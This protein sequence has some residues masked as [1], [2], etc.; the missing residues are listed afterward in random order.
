MKTSNWFFALTALVLSACNP[1]LNVPPTDINNQKLNSLLTLELGE[2]TVYTQDFIADVAMIDSVTVVGEGIEVMLYDSRRLIRVD[3]TEDAGELFD[4]QLWI[5]GNAYS[6][7]CR[8]SD[9]VKYNFVYDPQGATFERVQLAGQMNDWTPS[10][11]PDLVLNEQGKYETE[12]YL[13]PGTYLYQMSIDGEQNHDAGNP[14][15]VDNGYGKFNSILQVPGNHDRL[16]VLITRKAEHRKIYLSYQQEIQEL[17]VYWQNHRLPDH[18]VRFGKGEIAFDMPIEASKVERSYIRIWASNKF[19]VGREVLI[20]LH[21][22][23]PVNDAT[24]LTRKDPHTQIMYFM[25]VDRFKNGSVSND[26]PMNRPDVHPKVDYYGGDLAGLQQ[27]IDSGYFERLGVNTLWISPLS[28][29]P[30]E[31]YGYYAPKNTKFSGYHGYWPVSSSKV[32]DRF[33]SNEEFKKLVKKAHAREMNVLLDY[34]ANHV[35][36]QHPLYQRNPEYATSLYLPDGTMNVEK[37]DEHRL[38]TWFDTFMPSLDFSNP[39]VVEM[40]TDS[41]LFWLSEFELDG[42]RH[43]A[44]KHIP[45][46]FWRMLTL[47][48]KKKFPDKA[49]YQIGE[50]YGSPKLIAGYLTSGMLDGQFDFN[51]YDIA[52]TT[53]AGVA[54]DLTRVQDV[55]RSSLSNYG[56]H[57]LMGY[58]SGN[59]DKPRFMAYASGDLSMGEDAKAAGWERE[60][61]ITDSTAYDRLL[62]FHAFNLT[63]PGV[64]VLFYGDEIGLTGGN[65][66]DCRKMMRFEGWNKREKALWEKVAILNHLRRANPVLMYGSF[67]E[68][69]NSP[70]VW[71][72]AR[73]YFDREA[74]VV[75]NTSEQ[76]KKIT[77]NLPEYFDQES[78][79]STFG[80]TV[81][82]TGNELVVEL[83]PLSAEILL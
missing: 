28:Q 27:V 81:V 77:V 66:P 72:Y 61:G 57:N 55:L 19:G 39:D 24:Q 7:P 23:K 70:T 5:R 40:M 32:D 16:P 56:Q 71:V 64:P 14:Q 37:W 54:G 79:N 29:N 47:K 65:D 74:I 69:K 38:T 2:N 60:I 53:F 13:S 31:P 83:P 20:P 3:L 78:L 44:C 73:K 63:I 58:I 51:V 48:I 62:L 59:H 76:A 67:I 49:L 75:M 35:H 15:K 30:D 52:N 50:T 18:F 26:R 11:T 36:E 6:V 12:L 25:L 43:D 1:G 10:A 46:E 80:Y 9:K 4:V 34:V 82:R 8:K 33:G 21:K 17:A 68:L 22:G 45:E 42:F 41:A